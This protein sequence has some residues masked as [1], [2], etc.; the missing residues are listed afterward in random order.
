MVS[1]LSVFCP[2]AMCHEIYEILS[3]FDAQITGDE[4]SFS[5]IN[6]ITTPLIP[7]SS[8]IFTPSHLYEFDLPEAPNKDSSGI[9]RGATFEFDSNQLVVNGYVSS[10]SFQD[11][12]QR[13]KFIAVVS[14][15][16]GFS[17]AGYYTARLDLRPCASPMCGG[18]IM[19]SV[20]QELTR[21]ADGTSQPE[22]YIGTTNWNALGFDPVF[23]EEQPLSWVQYYLKGESFLESTM[24][25]ET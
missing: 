20:N 6:L 1:I 13:Y 4:I 23:A 11:P 12:I 3:T 9:Y 7:S 18:I 16:P 5:N 21:C 10:R 25:L 14:E 8:S 22:C 19:K 24:I 2:F 17:P 15:G